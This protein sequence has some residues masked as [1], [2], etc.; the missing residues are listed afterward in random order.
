MIELSIETA[1]GQ[2]NFVYIQEEFNYPDALE[3]LQSLNCRMATMAELRTIFEYVLNNPET[4]IP[5]KGTLWSS[6]AVEEKG[7]NDQFVM[8]KSFYGGKFGGDIGMEGIQPHI[9]LGVKLFL[10]GIKN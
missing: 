9:N 10:I 8:T 1:S 4:G 5:Q 6:D 7:R 3:K 2:L